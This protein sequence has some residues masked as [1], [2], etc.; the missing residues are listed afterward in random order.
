VKEIRRTR[1]IIVGIEAGTIETTINIKLTKTNKEIIINIL[2]AKTQNTG[3]III[4]HTKKKITKN[5]N[6]NSFLNIKLKIS[7]T[8]PKIMIKEKINKMPVV[9]IFIENIGLSL[10]SEKTLIKKSNLVEVQI[11]QIHQV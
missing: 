10:M 5:M 3:M 6:Q 2:K 4:T 1:T 11:V 9:R 7:M 8:M